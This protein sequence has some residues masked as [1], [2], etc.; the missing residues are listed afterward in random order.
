MR[1]LLTAL[2]AGTI[3]ALGAG[4]PALAADNIALVVEPQLIQTGGTVKLTANNCKGQ[5]A[6]ATFSPSTVGPVTL[7]QSVGNNSVWANVVIPAEAATGVYTITAN[8]NGSDVKATQSLY[9]YKAAPTPS[10]G[11]N[12]GG[13]ALDGGSGAIMTAT[14]VGIAGLGGIVGLLAWRRRRDA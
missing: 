13:I 3:L 10:H 6:T 1:R 2:S 8:C 4:T 9:V 5:T 7:N 12:T 14:G 11:P